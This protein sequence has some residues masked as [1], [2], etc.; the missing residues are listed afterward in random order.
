MQEQYT[1]SFGYTHNY[2]LWLL[3]HHARGL[4]QGTAYDTTLVNAINSQYKKYRPYLFDKSPSWAL[5]T[6]L[7]LESGRLLEVVRLLNFRHVLQ[8]VTLFAT[9]Q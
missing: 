8:V 1:L 6:L 2:C 7:D 9:K 5:G 3:C 4:C